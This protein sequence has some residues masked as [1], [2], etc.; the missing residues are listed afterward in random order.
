M[1]KSVFF[2]FIVVLF[3]INSIIAEEV[4]NTSGIGINISEVTSFTKETVIVPGGLDLI[5]KIFLGLDKEVEL[6]LLIIA[7]CCGIGV[8]YILFYA[9][10]MLPFIHNDFFEYILTIICLALVG[11]SGGILEASKTLLSF[12][13]VFKVFEDIPSLNLLVT[14]IIVVILFTILYLLLRFINRV[15]DKEKDEIVAEEA[16]E[17]VKMSRIIAKTYKK[18]LDEK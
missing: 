1:K 2:W 15:K 8:G 12:G 4:I 9:I 11:T 10:K 17:G 6:S 13:T 14:L 16:G 5:A 3:L 18:T 7:V